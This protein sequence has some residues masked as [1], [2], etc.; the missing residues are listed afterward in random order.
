LADFWPFLADFW[1]IFGLF[2]LIFLRVK[3]VENKKTLKPPF[4]TLQNHGRKKSVL[5][6]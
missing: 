6:P 1:L 5:T 2:W 4:G 3:N